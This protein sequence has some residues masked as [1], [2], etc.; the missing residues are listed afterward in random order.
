MK[1]LVLVLFVLLGSF[2]LL[3]CNATE[4]KVDGEFTAF[5]TSVHTNGAMQVTMVSVIIKDGQIASYNIDARQ[6]TR[7]QTAGADT[8]DV[9]TDDTYTFAW[10]V[11]TKKEL[12]TAYGMVTYGSAIAEWFVQAGRIEAYWLANGVDSIT[13]DDTNHINNVS[14]VTIKDGGYLALA[15]E[16]VELAKLGKFQA[17]YCTGTDLYIASMIVEKGEISE[18]KLNVLQKK[19][20]LAAANTFEWN[21]QTKQELGA[22][23][24][25]KNVGADYTYANGVW[26]SSATDKTQL[27]WFEQANQI[28][29]YILET[30]NLYA[31]RSVDGRGI[32][33][34][35]GAP[36]DACAGVSIKTDGYITVL[37][38]LFGNVAAGELK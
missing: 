2:A 12:G 33:L 3:G 9:T 21:T 23:Y 24:G 32:F 26:T 18:L 20:V 35:S 14:G 19:S 7:T 8:P 15:Q 30:G 16:A 22:A 4:F 1:K 25:M 10:N 36:V 17:I 27:E 38:T 31:I 13:V 34:T 6:G 5:A 28:T 11:K 29:N 37:N